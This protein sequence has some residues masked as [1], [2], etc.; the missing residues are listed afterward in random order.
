MGLLSRSGMPDER[1][2]VPFGP[3]LRPGTEEVGAA[4]KF[5]E[6]LLVRTLPVPINI[7]Q[8][9]NPPEK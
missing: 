4:E 9:F 6:K 8:F 7:E 1:K 3:Y 5:F 2:I